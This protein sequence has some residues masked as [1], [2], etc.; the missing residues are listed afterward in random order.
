MP[1]GLLICLS[2]VWIVRSEYISDVQFGFPFNF[3]NYLWSRCLVTGLFLACMATLVGIPL[4]DTVLKRRLTSIP[5]L[6]TAI[7][8]FSV[9]ITTQLYLDLRNGDGYN[10]SGNDHSKVVG[11]ESINDTFSRISLESL[12][13]HS[14]ATTLVSNCTFLEVSWDYKVDSTDCA[15][16]TLAWF[17]DPNSGET[18]ATFCTDGDADLPITAVN[19]VWNTYTCNA[20]WETPH[21]FWYDKKTKLYKFGMLGTKAA[22]LLGLSVVFGMLSAIIHYS[23]L[24]VGSSN[25]ETALATRSNNRYE[26]MPDVE[27]H[28]QNCA[29]DLR[30]AEESRL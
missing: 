9:A 22:Y 15:T 19:V 10:S 30:I 29:E 24:D 27:V 5:L 12:D 21:L 16:K 3:L 8:L 1:L 13:G 2:D 23:G 11:W 14:C 17:Q 6:M 18:L 26:E 4:P 7:Y 28:G 25:I 20:T